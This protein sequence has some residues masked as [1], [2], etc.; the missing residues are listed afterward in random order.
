[1]DEYERR[2]FEIQGEISSEVARLRKLLLRKGR[3][4]PVSTTLFSELINAT[5]GRLTG[6]FVEDL[7]RTAGNRARFV[8]DLLTEIDLAYDEYSRDIV[9]MDGA[10]RGMI[11]STIM[12]WHR[13]TVYRDEGLALRRVISNN[14]DVRIL[15]DAHDLAEVKRLRLGFVTGDHNDICN[16]SQAIMAQLSIREIISLRSFEPKLKA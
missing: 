2:H 3:N 5:K 8:D 16:N 7:Y 9:A 14:N 13:D 11:E 15:L 4:S 6:L 1:M 10:I 12:L